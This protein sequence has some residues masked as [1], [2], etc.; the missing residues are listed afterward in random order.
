MI[1]KDKDSKLLYGNAGDW[2]SRLDL[3]IDLYLKFNKKDRR[4][5]RKQNR[6]RKQEKFQESK[7]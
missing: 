7:G 6:I 3:D 1:K 5:I 2:G 4:R